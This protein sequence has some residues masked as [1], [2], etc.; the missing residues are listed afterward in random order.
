MV[1]ALPEGHGDDR[2]FDLDVRLDEV[3]RHVAGNAGLKP[4][5]QGCPDITVQATC[6]I[7]PS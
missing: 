3:A 5:D 1:T 2:E 6:T 4:T 7:Q